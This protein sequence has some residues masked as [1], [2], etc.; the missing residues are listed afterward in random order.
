[1]QLSA[2]IKGIISQRLIPAYMSSG[3]VMAYEVLLGSTSV[4]RCIKEDKTDQII[5]MMQTSRGEG[6]ITMDQCLED[7]VVQKRITYDDGFK[8]AADK[9]EFQKRLESRVGKAN[10]GDF[11]IKPLPPEEQDKTNNNNQP[12][13]R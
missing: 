3:R 2:S 12:P 4:K 10:A 1:M 13:K 11:G 7:L 8:N 9:K 6:M 5:S